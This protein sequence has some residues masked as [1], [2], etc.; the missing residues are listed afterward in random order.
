MTK[1]GIFIRILFQHRKDF[2]K[3]LIGTQ[4]TRGDGGERTDAC[5]RVEDQ[6]SE[7]Q[8]VTLQ[9]GFF[10]RTDGLCTDFGVSMGKQRHETLRRGG[11]LGER[12]HGRRLATE[13]FARGDG[14]TTTGQDAKTPDAMQALKGV[15]RFGSGLK[16]VGS[17]RSTG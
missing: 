4:S 11:T 17:V 14:G 2:G 5:R 6:F 7:R 1:Y 13:S 15:V 16:T 12:C 8:V 10:E 9:R 3:S